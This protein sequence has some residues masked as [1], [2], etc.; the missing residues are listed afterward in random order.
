MA[1]RSTSPVMTRPAPSEPSMAVGKFRR[2][3]D[4]GKGSFA[5]VYRGIHSVGP[6]SHRLIIR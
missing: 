1:G 2:L 4:I 5:M 3:N 6:L